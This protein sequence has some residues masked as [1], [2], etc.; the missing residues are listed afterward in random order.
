MKW[1]WVSRSA[2]DLL[3]EERDRLREQNDELLGTY[4]RIQRVRSGLRET[5]KPQPR[6]VETEKIPAEIEEIVRGFSSFAHRTNIR[7]Q[8]RG[9]RANGTPFSEIEKA[10]KAQ[11]VS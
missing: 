11:V 8:I 2:Y 5:P 6:K 9:M 7:D 10:L 1:P 4:T 3:M